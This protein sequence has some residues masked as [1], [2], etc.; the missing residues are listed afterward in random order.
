MWIQDHSTL[1]SLKTVLLNG[2]E[3]KTSSG[4]ESFSLGHQ[5]SLVMILLAAGNGLFLSYSSYRAKT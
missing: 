4:F 5:L 2:G 3:K 1:S